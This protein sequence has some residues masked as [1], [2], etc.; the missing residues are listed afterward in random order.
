MIAAVRRPSPS[1]PAACARGAV[2]GP[3]STAAAA[4]TVVK[5]LLAA[6]YLRPDLFLPDLPDLFLLGVKRDVSVKRVAQP[7]GV[8]IS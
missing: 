7:R 1:T 2:A 8:G 6:P 5:P 3:R 4:G